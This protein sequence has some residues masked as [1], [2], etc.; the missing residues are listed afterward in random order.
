MI[1][2]HSKQ[3][4]HQFSP[5]SIRGNMNVR[6]KHVRIIVHTNTKPISNGAGGRWPFHSAARILHP[7]AE[8]VDRVCVPR[9]QTARIYPL[10][11]I[12]IITFEPSCS[13]SNCVHIAPIPSACKKG[14][15]RCRR[16]H[17]TKSRRS[18]CYN[19]TKNSAAADASGTVY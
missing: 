2:N 13:H 7:N 9:N 12:M 10:R 1:T 19:N 4:H 8:H 6:Y 11:Q 14:Q 15:P 16:L 3:N 5:K 18:D 17:R